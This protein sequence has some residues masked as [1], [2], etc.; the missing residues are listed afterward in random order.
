METRKHQATFKYRQATTE[1]LLDQKE[2]ELDIHNGQDSKM[3]FT[4]REKRH[5]M[6]KV[7]EAIN[8]QTTHHVRTAGANIG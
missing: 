2:L 3:V 7:A 5:E 6:L 8:M 1:T 4:Q